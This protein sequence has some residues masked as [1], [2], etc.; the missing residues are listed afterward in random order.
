MIEKGAGGW[1]EV[2]DAAGGWVGGRDF[3]PVLIR[4]ANVNL[5]VKAAEPTEG[6]VAVGG[7][8]GGWMNRWVGGFGRGERGGW[9]ELL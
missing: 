6:G 2:L 7:W 3:L 8:V 9:N 1:N 4:H 5:T